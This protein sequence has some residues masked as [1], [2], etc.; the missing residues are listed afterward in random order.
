MY[1]KSPQISNEETLELI[2]RY[3]KDNDIEA[4]NQIILGNMGLIFSIAHKNRRK[5]ESS[6]E[7]FVSDG[8]IGMIEAINKFDTKLYTN[9]G[10]YAYYHI[11]KKVN[12]NLKMGTLS[13]PNH[14]TTIFNAYDKARAEMLQRGEVPELDVIAAKIGVST[15]ILTDTISRGRDDMSFDF[16]SGAENEQAMHVAAPESL[17]NDIAIKMDFAKA[18]ALIVTNLSEQEQEILRYRFGLDG[19]DPLTLEKTAENM[20]ISTE[21]VRL[22]QNKSLSKLKKL[23][24][25]RCLL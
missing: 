23:L 25:K 17:E 15:K 16:G 1:A 5:L 24:T 20:G 13:V 21:Y 3:Q 8:T 2:K 18:K 19:A 4:R 12:S 10:T 6:F 9:F 11:L 7:D 22:L 14:R